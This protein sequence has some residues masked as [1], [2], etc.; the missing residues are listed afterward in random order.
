M[1]VS[2]V[3]L[4]ELK[5]KHNAAPLLATVHIPFERYSQVE[6]ICLAIKVQVLDGGD[7]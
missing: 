3:H 7:L 4:H 6:G 5:R 2:H 1:Y